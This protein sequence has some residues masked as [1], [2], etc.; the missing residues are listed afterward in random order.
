MQSGNKPV[1][2][3]KYEEASFAISCMYSNADKLTVE[4]FEKLGLWLE[5]GIVNWGH[6][7]ILSGRVLSYFFQNNMLEIE[8]FASWTKSESIW[9]RR[10]V[11]VTLVEIVK[12]DMAIDRIFAVIDPLMMD[13]A[14]KVQQDLGWLLR[15]IWEKEPSITEDFLLKWKNSFGRTIIQYVTEKMD[16]EY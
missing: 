15:E 9:K 5:N 4:M 13:E 1:A 10:A 2:T 8:V 7:D 14:K 6:T 11:P 16:K 12:T 3:G